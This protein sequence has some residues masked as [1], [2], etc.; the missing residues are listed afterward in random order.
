MHFVLT[1]ALDDFADHPKRELLLRRVKFL[2][3]DFRN[4]DANA[5]GAIAKRHRSIFH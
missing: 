4:S 3:V 2:K 5:R 1:L